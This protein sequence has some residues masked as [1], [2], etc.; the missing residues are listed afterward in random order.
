M[1]SHAVGM[2]REPSAIALVGC[3]ET[4]TVL[5]GVRGRERKP[6]L[7]GA[8]LVHDPVVIVECLVNRYQHR[9]LVVLG[10][11]VGLLLPFFGFV[12]TWQCS[13]RSLMRGSDED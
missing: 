9:E 12:L 11:A 7:V 5:A 4:D 1:E 6:S 13:E 8:L 3:P 10:V 2:V